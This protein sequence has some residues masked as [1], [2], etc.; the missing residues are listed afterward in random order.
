MFYTSVRDSQPLSDFGRTRGLFCDKWTSESLDG[1]VST[2]GGRGSSAQALAQP[3]GEGAGEH[4][5]NVYIYNVQ[6]LRDPAHPSARTRKTSRW[7]AV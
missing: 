7:S 6:S 1:L 3:R 4:F 5:G 2:V